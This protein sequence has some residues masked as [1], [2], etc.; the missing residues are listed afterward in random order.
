M[1]SFVFKI[2]L[3]LSAEKAFKTNT[4]LLSNCLTSYFLNFK[5]Y[6][7]HLFNTNNHKFMKNYYYQITMTYDNLYANTYK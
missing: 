3:T 2:N 1:G 4:S 6:F 7:N 5:L